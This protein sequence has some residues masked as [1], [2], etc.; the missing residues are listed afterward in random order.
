MDNI[1]KFFLFVLLFQSC[2][3]D[4]VNDNGLPQTEEYVIWK[5]DTF[6]VK[7]TSPNMVASFN[8]DNTLSS[9]KLGGYYNVTKQN[10]EFEF[11]GNRLSGTYYP[12]SNSFLVDNDAL[13]YF[14]IDDDPVKIIV[15]KY[16]DTGDFII[17]SFSGY[18]KDLLGDKHWISGNF[19]IRTD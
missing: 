19:K 5:I 9:T 13:I 12:F 3:K 1:L 15:S 18:V 14:G 11:P 4:S 8:R 16:G 10:L 6:D 17:G 2:K 7:L